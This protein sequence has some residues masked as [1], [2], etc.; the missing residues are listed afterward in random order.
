MNL[1]NLPNELKKQSRF[2]I[3]RPDGAAVDT[4]GNLLSSTQPDRWLDFITAKSEAE[5]QDREVCWLCTK[6][7]FIIDL[8]NVVNPRTGEVTR[9]SQAILSKF[10]TFTER[11]RSG[12]G[13]HIIGRG[14]HPF[15]LSRCGFNAE[16]PNQFNV[17]EDK[18]K[19]EVYSTKIITLTGDVYSDKRLISDCD[20]AV[21]QVVSQYNPTWRDSIGSVK[22]QSTN[23]SETL[24]DD[25][26]VAKVIEKHPYFNTVSFNHGD[27]DK[28]FKICMTLAFYTQRDQSRMKSILMSSNR[29]RERSKSKG[30]KYLD[31]KISDACDYQNTV[32]DAGY[33]KEAP[34]HPTS[35]SGSGKKSL[36]EVFPYKRTDKGNADLLI[37]HCGDDIR[38]VPQ[39]GCW[40][41][42]NGKYWKKCDSPDPIMSKLLDVVKGCWNVVPSIDSS[43]EKKI[44]TQWLC[45]C[46]NFNYLN[47]AVRV[48]QTQEQVIASIEEFDSDPNLFN[49]ANGTIDLTTGK[50][51][52]HRREDFITKCVDIE[53]DPS[54]VSQDWNKF[55]L[56]SVCQNQEYA[57]Y[58]QRAVGYSLHGTPNEEVMFFIEG[59]AGTGKGTFINTIDAVFG[60]MQNYATVASINT[61][62]QKDRQGSA[63]SGDIARL[64]GYRLVYVHEPDRGKSFNESLIKTLT[65]RD[66]ITARMLYQDEI[67]FSP[68]FTLWIT[69]NY[70]V[71]FGEKEDAVKRRL[72][73]LKFLNKP[74][75]VNTRLKDILVQPDNLKGILAWGVKGCVDALANGLQEPQLLQ[76]W[77]KEYEASNNILA[78]FKDDMLQVGIAYKCPV[79][80]FSRAVN[81]W[82]Q[83]YGFKPLTSTRINEAMRNLGFEE[84]VV[85]YNKASTRCWIGVQVKSEV[86]NDIAAQTF[87]EKFKVA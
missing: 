84:K 69:S 24:S 51:A 87:K 82:R 48:A 34:R 1:S 57:D 49:V 73:Y 41:C 30:Q 80:E 43:D 29:F 23:S 71:K 28:D 53:Y 15:L 14:T 10:H 22:Q 40:F 13:F 59:E 50:L 56:D 37:D 46:E 68:Q 60:G 2:G 33:C 31:D 38:Y 75:V 70:K 78:E 61:L 86:D 85:R 12:Q 42:W 44:L 65:G 27:N 83:T 5:R 54:A 76:D 21:E 74:K 55:I 7:Y 3:R 47:H 72:K 36:D 19:I 39:F 20:E 11:S 18:P 45:K 25:R 17:N 9:D 26:I 77:Q 63:A 16:L 64:K 62:T 58:L 8:D 81:T 79:S 35:V 6:P 4:L 66:K 32:Y 67:S 52:P